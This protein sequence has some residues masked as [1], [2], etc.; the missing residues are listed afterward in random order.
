MSTPVLIGLGLLGV[1]V[2]G[3]YI[4]RRMNIGSI[5]E[6]VRISGL[7]DS[8]YY[9]GGFEQNM[10]KREAALILGVSQQS[11]KNKIKEAHKRIMLL[12]HPDKVISDLNL[13]ESRYI[14]SYCDC[15]QWSLLFH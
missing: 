6:L 14:R 8:K 15:I 13:C 7:S 3:R 4:S 1:G 9:K 2:A 5:S 12:N 10:S 11:G